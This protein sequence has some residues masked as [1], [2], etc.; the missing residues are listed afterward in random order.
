MTRYLPRMSIVP[1]TRRSCCALIVGTAAV[2]A[3]CGGGG[4]SHFDENQL[5][6]DA[7]TRFN[8]S[9]FS[10][11][12]MCASTPS[13]CQE[14]EPQSVAPV[15]QAVKGA[16]KV[17]PKPAGVA[18]SADQPA[19]AAAAATSALTSEMLMDWAQQT[20]PRVFPGPAN[21]VV[22]TGFVFRF[23]P[24]TNNFIAVKDDG[25]V[26]ILP[27]GGQLTY[28]APMVDFTCLV[29]PQACDVLMMSKVTADPTTPNYSL[30]MYPQ[31]FTVKLLNVLGKPIANQTVAWAAN[32][33]GWAIPSST[34]T[35]TDGTAQV[36]WVPGYGVTPQ[37]TATAS[38]NQGTA[39]VTYSGLLRAD[40]KIEEQS[41][42][43]ASYEYWDG[44]GV[45]GLSREITPLTEPTGTYY[46]V[47]GWTGG[48]TG[49]ARG[50][51]M[52][53]RQIQFSVWDL[54][55]GAAL[56]IDSGTSKCRPF[57]GEGTGIACENTYPW[58]I[59]KTYRFEMTTATV[60]AG[61]TDISM[62]FVDVASGF[63]LFLG[64]LRQA[65]VPPM[66]TAYAFSEDFKRDSIGCQNVPERRA[67]FGNTKVLKGAT[68]AKAVI[69][70]FST[71]ISSPI[72]HCANA[73]HTLT[74]TGYELGIGGTVR[75]T[76]LTGW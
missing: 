58:Q 5:T 39:T 49:I 48:Y 74:A 68:W 64:T 65:S 52:Y 32:G 22:R 23:Y 24:A 27:S 63:R 29:T 13:L 47:M 53:D 44:Q 40:V 67:S 42:N 3:G 50:G 43:I 12:F 62:Y 46:A 56:L 70:S 25:G 7:A 18:F 30:M 55:G 4:S 33:N 60:V 41:P 28:I 54:T 75:N 38:N 34:K 6:D 15:K 26:Y 10:T 1:S 76:Q 20:F 35:G 69:T 19:S 73:G 66:N 14:D 51:S 59:N 61:R 72:T 16:L 31:K 37:L 36:N 17:M 45:T 11:S 2:L 9:Q 21:T 71:Q 57:G 8:A